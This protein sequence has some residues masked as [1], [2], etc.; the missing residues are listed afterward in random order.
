MDIIAK[1]FGYL[2]KFCY[3]FT[4]SYAL[5][6]LFFTLL[7]KLILLPLSIKQQKSSQAQARI[8]PKEMAIRKRYEGRTDPN[9]RVELSNDL[10]K[11]YQEEKVSAAGGCLPLLIQLPIIYI[12]YQIITKPLQYICMVSTETIG[13]L[14]TKMF[15]LF[16]TGE[17]NASNT[18][19]KIAELFNDAGG[20]INK[21]N[22]S[23]IQMLSVMEKNQEV[24][25]ETLASQNLSGIVY[26]DFTIFGGAIDLSSTPTF[27]SV[28]ILIPLLAAL[29]QFASTFIMKFFSPK[30]DMSVP[31]AAETQKTMFYM[32]II[33]PAMTFFMAFQFPAILGLYWIYQSIFGT[34]IQIILYKALPIPV[35]TPEQIAE[36]EAE[37]N[38][39]YVRPEIKSYARSLHNIDED[40]YEVE[41][42]D[43]T[44]SSDV[45]LADGSG[46][47]TLSA[48]PP[49]RRYDKNGNKIRS[50]HFIDEDDDEEITSSEDIEPSL[51]QNTDSTVTLDNDD[52]TS[53]ETKAVSSDSTEKIDDAV[54][55]TVTKPGEVDTEGN[56]AILE[57]TDI[58]GLSEKEESTEEN[59]D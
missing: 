46:E 13:A 30:P 55:D 44:E 24:F 23:E 57:S 17:L 47:N 27:L 11:L 56:D 32:N 19:S 1:P 52:L 26:P 29:F 28:M 15:E 4:N 41:Y 20:A 37:T 49:R 2:L 8:R 59:N 18:S 38:K 35:Y 42:V 31:G 50:L 58:S 43:K 3:D 10:M 6:L 34:V 25:A 7:F 36:I 39:D 16:G 54:T 40:D 14:K 45:S 12:L 5:A 21:F 22:V 9:A 51:P 53:E 48:V 33:F